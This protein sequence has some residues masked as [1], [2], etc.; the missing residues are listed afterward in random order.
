MNCF[1]HA[2]APAVG[3]CKHCS[4]GLCQQCAADVEGEGLACT[5]RH[6]AQVAALNA[7]MAKASTTYKTNGAMLWGYS[8]GFLIFGGLGLV[9]SIGT[10]SASAV[11]GT[12]VLA[13]AVFFLFF[14]GVNAVAAWRLRQQRA[15]RSA[16]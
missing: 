1:Y 15:P 5:N 6:E 12:I 9:A 2:N 8:V 10:F 13:L 4:R 3:M 11:L 7:M 16:P 14:G